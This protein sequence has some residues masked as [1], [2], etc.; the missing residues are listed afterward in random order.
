MDT[1]KQ[2]TIIANTVTKF[3]TIRNTTTNVFGRRSYLASG[4]YQ[5]VDENDKPYLI[6]FKTIRPDNEGQTISEGEIPEK[7]NF[8][9]NDYFSFAGRVYLQAT[10][11]FL[12]FDGGTKIEHNCSNI[13][14]SYLK[15]K[16]E[17]NP[18]DIQIPIPKKSVDMRGIAVG[19]GLFYSPDSNAVFASFLSLQGSRSSKEVIEAEGLLTYDKENQT[20]E[21]SNKEKL[22]EMSLPGNYVSLNTS[23][24]QM[25]TEGRFDI[26]TDLGQVK[27]SCIGNAGL[28]TVTDSVGFN[29]MMSVDFYFE[30][31]AIKKMA[32][33]FEVYLGSLNPVPFEGDL[34]NHGIIELLG[35]ER[36]DRA[37]SE[38]NLYGNYKK[39]PDE[40]E[41]NLVLNEVKL[42]YN[43]RAKAYISQ[44]QL[45][46]GNIQKTEIFRYM[47]GLIQV[48]KQKAGDQIDIYIAPDANTWYY[49]SYNRN[50]MQAVSSNDEFNK[51]IETLKSK[52]KKLEVEKG[53]SYR[54]DIMK[55]SKKD[56]FLDKMKQVGA[57]G[58]NDDSEDN[59][60]DKD[61][62]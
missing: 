37:L 19:T 14:K 48:K 47:D 10:Q 54:F 12:T 24:C 56:A 53:P 6:Y 13:G 17:I 50:F 20:Y 31:S 26:S 8:K 25:Y 9:F 32:K 3:H 39:F 4:E 34:F 41:K 59:K 49:F 16:G 62:N 61:E 1:L 55:K 22:E 15:F 44:G 33:D 52:N 57:F 43:S 51:S 11:Q 18:R 58:N 35:K 36:G 29:L 23:N 27:L 38:L 5:Y 45:G 7:D 60:K 28:N 21:I 40:L 30:N 46:V 42:V 2:S